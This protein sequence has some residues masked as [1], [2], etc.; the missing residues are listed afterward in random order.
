MKR[1]LHHGRSLSIEL[2]LGVALE[3]ARVTRGLSLD[4][5][6]NAAKI[7]LKH[8]AEYEAG[9]RRPSALHLVSLSLTLDTPISYLFGLLSK[10]PN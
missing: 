8:L 1:R 9:T 5:L 10:P 3:E 6:S 7:S 4:E 2:A